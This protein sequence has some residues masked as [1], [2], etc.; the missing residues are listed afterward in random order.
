MK[1]AGVG[2][3][4]QLGSDLV[5]AFT[6]Y[7]DDVRALTHSHIEIADPDSVSRVFEELQPQV[8]V[9]TAAMHHVENCECEPAKAFSVNGLGS[10]N[11]AVVA[12]RLGTILMHVSTD[13]V[14]DG[15][16]G[17]PYTE[18]DNPHP[19]NAYGITKLA[20]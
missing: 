15:G 17:I 9:N 16:K 10:K 1:I 19:L 2:A 12:Q 18:D 3:E 8:I 11:L 13:Y 5:A 6:A 4:G 20:G 7:G 14:F